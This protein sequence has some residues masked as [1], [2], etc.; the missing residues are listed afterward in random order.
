MWKLK[1]C[2]RCGGDVFMDRE[3]NVWHQQCLQCG[4]QRELKDIFEFK[5]KSEGEKEPVAAK[6][7]RAHTK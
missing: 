5:A 3:L 2:P 6:R 7:H 1:A 4:Y